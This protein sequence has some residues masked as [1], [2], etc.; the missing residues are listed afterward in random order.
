ML[1][2]REGLCTGPV[3]VPSS[4]SLI[5]RPSGGVGSSLSLSALAAPSDVPSFR[6]YPP[7]Q[8]EWPPSVSHRARLSERTPTL[9]YSLDV[10]RLDPCKPSLNH[11]SSSMTFASGTGTMQTHIDDSSSPSQIKA[12][13]S[14]PRVV[15][16]SERSS[17]LTAPWVYPFPIQ[18]SSTRMSILIDDTS[19]ALEHS[20]NLSQVSEEGHNR[21]RHV[22]PTCLMRF[23]RPSSL[24]THLNSHTGATREFDTFPLTLC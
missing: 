10:L 6:N 4:G 22:C 11:L 5:H 1:S 8:P 18:S 12:S 17:P 3:P 21:R 16:R 2:R 15:C 20:P 9:V 24:H 19:Y 13:A 23:N 7:K 14:G